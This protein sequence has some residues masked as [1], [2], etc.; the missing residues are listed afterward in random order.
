MIFVYVRQLSL[1]RHHNPRLRLRSVNRF[2]WTHIMLVCRL[3]RGV[4][5]ATATLWTVINVPS[6]TYWD[7]DEPPAIT[8]RT[9]ENAMKWFNLILSRSAEAPLELDFTHTAFLG[10]AFPIL[11][12]ESHRI[13]SL[14]VLDD[15]HFAQAALSIL[16]L[17]LPAIVELDML[18]DEDSSYKHRINRLESPPTRRANITPE[19][20][21]SLRII[22]LSNFALPGASAS[23]IFPQ[24]E[25]LDL[26]FC[27]FESYPASLDNLLGV[28][29]GCPILVE[30]QLHFVLSMLADNAPPQVKQTIPLN[31]LQKLVL[32]DVS[33]LTRHF[34]KH[35]SVPATTTLRVIGV[36]DGHNDDVNPYRALLS[37]VP[38][39][40]HFPILGVLTEGAIR[41][42]HGP[43]QLELCSP[44]AKLSV[45][46]YQ[47]SHERNVL[48]ACIR[49][50]CTLCVKS[51]LTTLAVESDFDQVEGTGA[52]RRLFGTFRTLEHLQLIGKGSILCLLSTLGQPPGKQSA[53][54]D[55]E[56]DDL[57]ACPRLR[58]IDIFMADWVPGLMEALTG[59]LRSRAASGLSKL[60]MIGMSLGASSSDGSVEEGNKAV[61]WYESEIGSYVGCFNW[62]V[63]DNSYYWPLQ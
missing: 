29:A 11:A 27:S 45:R 58:S 10:G 47:P 46:V 33:L 62:E 39:P 55:A 30:L 40:R 41:T 32:R 54:A 63:T 43:L 14:S 24:L 59:V 56:D 2:K 38:N 13:R 49:A 19:R 17:D 4:A 8:I 51:P 53:D 15:L 61:E 18:Y 48:T 9:K 28:L 35:I 44:T 50:L 57:P 25:R 21:P 22:R 52:W 26:R 34:L 6:E 12:T 16:Q 31:K 42:P 7:Q 60:E 5:L 23:M 1:A 36:V 20:Y 37:I 3:W